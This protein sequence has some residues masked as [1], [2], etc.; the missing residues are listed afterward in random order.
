MGQSLSDIICSER[1][2]AAVAFAFILR[3]AVRATRLAMNAVLIV[4]GD[5]MYF[6]PCEL[7]IYSLLPLKTNARKRHRCL[8]YV[9]ADTLLKPR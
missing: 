9:M 7:A 4:L 3:A 8:L 5:A 1:N 6:A 2:P